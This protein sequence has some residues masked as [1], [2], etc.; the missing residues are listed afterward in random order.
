M[1]LFFL[2][3]LFLFDQRHFVTWAQ[4]K[5]EIARLGFISAGQLVVY[6]LEGREA[7]RGATMDFDRRTSSVPR[8]DEMLAH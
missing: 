1:A 2:L 5:G 8:L 4:K 7:T 6:R 3:F